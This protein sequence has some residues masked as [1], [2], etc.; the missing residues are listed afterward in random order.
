MTLSPRVRAWLAAHG[1]TQQR[2]RLDEAA[3]RRFCAK[4]KLPTWPSLLAIEAR[5]GGLRG[6]ASDSRVLEFGVSTFG[7]RREIDGRLHLLVAFF[8]PILWYMDEAGRIVEIDDLGHRFYESD[9]IDHRIE[10]LAVYDW[11]A[12]HYR[13]IPG[14][15]GHALAKQLD[16][17]YISE[18]SDSR[19]RHWASPISGILVRESLEPRDYGSRDLVETTWIN[20]RTKAALDRAPHTVAGSGRG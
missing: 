4:N 16:L 11:Q 9:T 5:F 13:S 20:A 1:V 18:A 10:Q 17:I 19:Q 2:P 6:V 14:F 7:W 15:H 3:T 12:R 8:D